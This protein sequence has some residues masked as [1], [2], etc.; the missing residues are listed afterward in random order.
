MVRHTAGRNQA[1]LE[2]R[3][4]FLSEGEDR[5]R[6]CAGIDARNRHGSPPTLS[7]WETSTYAGLL[8][9]Q[10]FVF[11]PQASSRSASATTMCS[12]TGQDSIT[13]RGLRANGELV[14]GKT[15][16]VVFARNTSSLENTSHT[17]LSAG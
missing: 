9:A 13:D 1:L 17:E 11:L 15:V 6:C 8:P 10:L 14:D 5:K 3:P 7:P 16:Q 2:F 12:F 4:A